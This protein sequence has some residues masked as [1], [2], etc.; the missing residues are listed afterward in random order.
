MR[1]S[2]LDGR[3]VIT[4]EIDLS[5]YTCRAV[6]DWIWVEFETRA[7]NLLDA[8]SLSGSRP[9]RSTLTRR[10]RGSA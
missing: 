2:R 5:V 10:W 1:Q 4:P 3:L 6:I 8:G 9:M 7:A